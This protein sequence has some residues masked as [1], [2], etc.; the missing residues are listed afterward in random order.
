MLLR[1]KIERR[2]PPNN[3][4]ILIEDMVIA[5]TATISF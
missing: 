4:N 5:D 3:K 2:P 1:H